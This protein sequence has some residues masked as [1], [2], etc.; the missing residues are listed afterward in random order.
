FFLFFTTQFGA[1]SILRERREGTLS[2]LLA[3]PVPKRAIVASKALYAYVLGVGSMSVLVVA[4]TLLIGAN[5]GKVVP[6]A[7]LVAA[8]VFAAMGVQSLGIT[9]ADNEEQ[10][11]GFG[12]LTAVVLGLLGGTLFPL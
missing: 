2:R 3:S 5:W 8:G 1:I 11:S 9:L 6:V 10:A 7:A 12:A 4:T